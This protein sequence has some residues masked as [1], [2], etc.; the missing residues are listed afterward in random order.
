MIPLANTLLLMAGTAMASGDSTGTCC[1]TPWVAKALSVG[2]SARGHLIA[3]RDD[4][5]H[6]KTIEWDSTKR[7]WSSWDTLPA[8]SGTYSDP[9]VQAVE[10]WSTHGLVNNVFALNRNEMSTIRTSQWIRTPAGTQT[11]IGIGESDSVWFRPASARLGVNGSQA[12]FAVFRDSTLR[13]RTW[14]SL[15][16]KWSGWQAME[17]KTGFPPTATQV[18]ANNVN[19]YVTLPDGSIR[20]NWWRTNVWN[21]WVVPAYGGAASEPSSVNTNWYDHLLF[22]FSPA[23]IPQYQYWNGGSWTSWANLKFPA[24]RHL[25]PVVAGTD[26]ILLY[27]LDSTNQ[28]VRVGWRKGRGWGHAET[29]GL[30]PRSPVFRDN[31]KLAATATPEGFLLAVRGWNDSLY[32]LPLSSRSAACRQWSLLPEQPK[33]I[34]NP[35]LQPRV[36][37][38]NNLFVLGKVDSQPRIFQ[39]MYSKGDFLP[40]I[41]IGEADSAT[42]LASGRLDA[43]GRQ[44]LFATFKDNSI[45]MRI[46]DSL[47]RTWGGWTHLQQ[48]SVRSLSVSQ[49]DP[50]RLQLLAIDAHVGVHQREWNQSEWQP[51]GTL[52]VGSLASAA[53]SANFDE[54][55]QVLFGMNSDGRLAENVRAGVAWSGWRTLP[56]FPLS[57]PATVVENGILNLF[58]INADS[59][60]VLLRRLEETAWGEPHILGK[61]PPTR[62]CVYDT[63]PP[64]SPLSTLTVHSGVLKTTG[65][66]AAFDGIMTLIRPDGKIEHLEK[67]AGVKDLRIPLQGLGFLRYGSETVRLIG[68]R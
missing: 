8:Q 67:R 16:R 35:W 63:F 1:G 66:L 62:T 34:S 38:Y 60:L 41:G 51:W 39:W 9:W 6:L 49:I 64:L 18:D 32:T 52:S 17:M 19:V 28:I 20:Q 53:T 42:S 58:F 23:G 56:W 45:R 24:K 44:A 2:N 25:S 5:G 57:E 15:A 27:G 43:L 14:D 48:N 10:G 31:R 30:C 54:N 21:G 3:I 55:T 7:A 40:T 12:L 61:I 33:T 50:S 13:M 37:P 65:S 26:S 68:I 59:N 4:L 47:A 36:G 46:W 11:T 22:S 29:L